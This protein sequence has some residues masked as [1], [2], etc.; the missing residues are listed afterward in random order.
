MVA[1]QSLFVYFSDAGPVVKV[2]MLILLAA[3]IISWT[4]IFQRAMYLKKVKKESRNFED[5]FWSGGKLTDLYSQ[6]SSSEQP[7]SGNALIFHDGFK[8]YLRLSKQSELSSEQ[9]MDG[10]QRAMRIAS[11]REYEQME[12]NLPFLA[13]VGSTSPY[14][15]LFG[16]VW[17][18]MTSFH[19]LGNVQTAT[20]AMVAPGISEALIA[21]AMGLFAAIPAVLAYNRYTA[22][23]ERLSQHFETFQEE[24]SSI[25]HRQTHGLG[26]HHEA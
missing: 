24:L 2:V 9:V 20:I 3:S 22:T 7:L 17:G 10:V 25:L 26:A 12:S 1:N 19:A 11:N 5:K 16:T 15:G 4:Y 14:I 18:I 6:L 21:T 8:E 23:V 13:S